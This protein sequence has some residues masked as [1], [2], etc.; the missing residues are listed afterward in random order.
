MLQTNRVARH[1]ALEGVVIVAGVLIALGADA[2]W[3]YR[4]DRSDEQVVLR[5]LDAELESNAA[6]LESVG[7][8][9][10]RGLEAATSLLSAVRGTTTLTSDSVRILLRTLDMAW[11]YNPK[12]A[13]LESVI[14]SGRLGLIR[15]DAL[16]VELTGWPAVVEDFREEEE[17][18]RRY[19]QSIQFAALSEVINWGDVFGPESGRGTAEIRIE[20]DK[21]LESIIAY[22]HA[23]FEEVLLELKVTEA[24]LTRMRTLLADDLA[25]AS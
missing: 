7:A 6:M 14:Q 16:R 11:T 8:E 10:R 5:Q 19:T 2:L 24:V 12:L 25:G 15:N 17:G 13:A 9:H 3:S 22:R 20:G 23:W 21:K 4:G 18:A 1:Y